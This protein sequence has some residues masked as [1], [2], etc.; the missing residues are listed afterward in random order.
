M[1]GQN[2]ELTRQSEELTHQ[3]ETINTAIGKN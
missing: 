3:N 1:A 2:E